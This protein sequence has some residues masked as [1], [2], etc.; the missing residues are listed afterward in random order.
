MRSLHVIT[1][2]ARRGA[3]TFAV[4]LAARLC[5]VGDEARVVTLTASDEGAP[6]AVPTLGSGR[7]DPRGLQALR[8]ATR[9][10]DVVVAHGSSTLE[11]CAIALA[12]TGTPFVYRIIGDPTYWTATGTRRRRVNALLRRATRHVTL[13]PGAATDLAGLARGSLGHAS[14]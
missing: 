7:R 3:E 12:E 8:R 9:G 14:T 11:S 2:T 13:W 5:E 10:A 4:D 1:S 6:H